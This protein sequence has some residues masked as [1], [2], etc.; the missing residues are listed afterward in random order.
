M[1]ALARDVLGLVA[2]AQAVTVSAGDVHISVELD[3]VSLEEHEGSRSLGLT[4]IGETSLRGTVSARDVHISVE[5]DFGSLE[6]HEGSRSLGL[7]IIGEAS[8]RGISNSFEVKGRR[9]RIRPG[10]VRV[11]VGSSFTLVNCLRLK[12]PGSTSCCK[13]RHASW[14]QYIK[15]KGKEI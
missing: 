15:Y 1:G 13:K 10:E 2:E 9:A 12:L 14:I 5:L 11:P 3:F 8:L 6:E 7:T 4:I